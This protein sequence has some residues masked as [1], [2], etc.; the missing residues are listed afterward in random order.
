MPQQPSPQYPLSSR[1][2]TPPK[3]SSSPSYDPFSL[4]HLFKE[5]ST[6]DQT[7]HVQPSLNG[8]S[9]ADGSKLTLYELRVELKKAGL[10]PSGFKADLVNRFERLKAGTLL[11][12]DYSVDR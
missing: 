4:D 1:Y 3:V 12:S 9:S 10:K 5:R 2:S 11:P 6:L 7:P 8:S